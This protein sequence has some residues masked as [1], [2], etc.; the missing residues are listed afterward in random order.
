MPEKTVKID[1]DGSEIMSTILLK[2][3]NTCP[4]L[5]KNTVTFSTLGEDS[6]VAFFPGVGAAITNE[7]ESVTGHVYQMCTYP[8]DILWRAAPKTEGAKIR[9]KEQ[10][11]AIGRWL[12]R[13]PVIVD[14]VTYTMQEYPDLEVGQ[15]LIKSI[16]RT[17]PAHL[18]SLY[19][20]GVEDWMISC[21]LRYE[22]EFD[23]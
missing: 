13:Q 7:R 23:R 8:F 15:R 21:T 9:I 19:Q 17:T 20:N 16:S 18:G 2:L 12:E 5:G 1:V 11:D 4:A 3:V 6:G 22:N 10:L 14:G